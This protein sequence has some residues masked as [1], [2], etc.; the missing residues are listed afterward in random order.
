MKTICIAS[1]KGGVGKS[2]IA[3][4][5]AV[6]AVKDNKS[7]LIIDGDTQ[8]S[9]M[10]F[11]EFRETNDIKAISIPKPTI[12]KDIADFKNFDLII[13]DVGGRDN[14]AFRSGIIASQYGMILIPIVPSQFDITETEN[15]YGVIQEVS[16]MFDVKAYS[17]F[18]QVNA[19]PKV[20]IS[21]EAFKLVEEL[22]EEYGIKSVGTILHSRVPFADSISH[23]KG[24]LEY[25]PKD[26]SS[27]E[28]KL[29]Y[30]EI[31]TILEI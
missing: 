24:V 1:S 5:L 14:P 8:G 28:I 20:K 15:T 29:L 25:K 7:V 23:G 31:K 12:H 9:S 13:V 27:D 22:N 26:K 16:S 21:G 3:V 11:R 10:I 4:N 17:V 30:G 6:C 18:N 2:T 19:N